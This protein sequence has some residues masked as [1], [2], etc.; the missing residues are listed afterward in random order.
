MSWLTDWT[1][2]DGE[3]LTADD[4]EALTADDGEALTADEGEALT[5]DE[6]EAV[7]AGT[8]CLSGEVFTRTSGPRSSGC[9]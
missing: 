6:G 4:G 5:A 7:T 3:A 2:D 1:A 9:S 8:L